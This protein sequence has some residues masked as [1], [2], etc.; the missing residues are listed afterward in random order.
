MISWQVSM[1][2]WR[3]TGQLPYERG[4]EEEYEWADATINSHTTAH[5]LVHSYKWRCVT[6][7]EGGGGRTA[8]VPVAAL[9]LPLPPRV[10]DC[11]TIIII[12]TIHTSSSISIKNKKTTK[13]RLVALRTRL[14]VPATRSSSSSIVHL[15]RSPFQTDSQRLPAPHNHKTNIC[16]SIRWDKYMQ[17]NTSSLLLLLLR[18][19]QSRSSTRWSM[20]SISSSPSPRK[21]NGKRQNANIHFLVPHTIS[22]LRAHLVDWFSTVL[23]CVDRRLIVQ[24]KRLSF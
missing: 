4:R 18:H 23:V 8:V 11:T 21:I 14:S 17:T 9:R 13:K 16:L 20:S 2:W 15:A 22:I 12:S 7:E 5:R 6:R 1:K 19:R 24:L 3:Q 10:L